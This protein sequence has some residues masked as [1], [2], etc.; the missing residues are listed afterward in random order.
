[1]QLFYVQE[2]GNLEERDKLEFAEDDAYLVDDK[3]TIYI[4]IGRGIPVNHKDSA[5]RAAR[6]LNR[7]KGKSAK[8]ILLDQGQE[9]GAFMFLMEVLKEG[10]PSDER[11]EERGQFELKAPED[12]AESEPEEA[13]VKIDN[14]VGWLDQLKT[15]RGTTSEE[16]EPEEKEKEVSAEAV[17]EPVEAKTSEVAEEKKVEAEAE[18]EFHEDQVVTRE[19]PGV[20]AWVEQMNTYRSSELE[21][22]PEH[23]V[24]PMEKEEVIVEHIPKEEPDEE[25]IEEPPSPEELRPE[26]N[27]SAYF[28]SKENHTYDKLCW[29]LAEKQLS[30]QKDPK[31]PS[32]EEIRQKAAEVSQSSTSY[33]ELCWLLAELTIY[34]K[35]GYFDMF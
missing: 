25:P 20:T 5:V 6:A 35:Y 33:D 14:V 34:K 1:M 7:E 26:I 12:I 22:E 17:E 21:A 4:W 30:I 9:Y 13:A 18:E 24:A 16:E 27:L 3:N 11:L 29:L 8:L 10:V 15:Y 28:L 32:E 2:K 31:E 23:D 19:R